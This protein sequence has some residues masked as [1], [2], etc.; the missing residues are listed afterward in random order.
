MTNVQR[1]LGARPLAADKLSLL[2]KVARMYHERGLRQP[3][4]AEQ[5]NLSQS[6]VSRL[7]KEA[8][9]IGVVRT[10]VVAPAGVHTDLEDRLRSAFGLR[11]VVVVDSPAEGD[12]E[13]LLAALGSGG[14]GYLEAS[15]GADD[16]IGISSWSSSLLAVLNAMAPRTT[17]MARQVVQILGGVGNPAAQ[18]KATHLADGLARVTGGEAV[19]LPLPG[20]VADPSVVRVLLDDSYT[21]EAPGLWNK[22]TVALVGIG[23]LHPSELLRSSGN[24]ISPADESALRASGA[25]GD[26]CLRFFDA[27]G[28]PIANELD[29]RVIGITTEQ[30]RRTPRRIGVAGGR[31]KHEAILAAVRGKWVNVLVTDEETADFLL[32]SA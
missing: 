19:Y 7:L 13:S 29:A 23:S 26:V 28:E 31:R 30:L 8:V 16:R 17:R 18:V 25:V 24:A 20:I 11:D 32:A 22:L 12:E 10:I 9:D 3:E 2:T 5:L 27:A 1:P 15:L 4:I 14:A 6:R 21:G